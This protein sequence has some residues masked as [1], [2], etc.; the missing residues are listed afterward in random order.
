MCKDGYFLTCE[1]HLRLRVSQHY[2]SPK[3]FQSETSVRSPQI[4]KPYNNTIKI[5]CMLP[6]TGC[7]HLKKP[8]KDSKNNGYFS[9]QSKILLWVGAFRKPFLKITIHYN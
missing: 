8:Y 6:H 1:V 7:K 3:G 4:K 5:R 9:V 2:M